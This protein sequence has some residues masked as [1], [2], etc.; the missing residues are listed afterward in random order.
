MAY[1]CESLKSLLDCLL[2]VVSAARGLATVDKSSDHGLIGNI[3][4]K[5][6]SCWCKL[7]KNFQNSFRN[8]DGSTPSS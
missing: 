1:G 4:V 2:V 7:K 5:N 6:G 8:R 3:Q